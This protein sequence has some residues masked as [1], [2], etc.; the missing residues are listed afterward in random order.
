[1]KIASHKMTDN[2]LTPN[3]HL[4]YRNRFVDNTDYGVRIHEQAWGLTFKDNAY[5]GNGENNKLRVIPGTS[6]FPRIFICKGDRISEDGLDGSETT[7][8]YVARD[9]SRCSLNTSDN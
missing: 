1:M 7:L 3:N 9:D 5:A 8:A 4:Y 2:T 6:R